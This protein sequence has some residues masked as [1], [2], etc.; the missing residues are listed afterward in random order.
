MISKNSP[1]KTNLF[2]DLIAFL[3][4][5]IPVTIAS[6]IHLNLVRLFNLS[7]IQVFLAL[8][9]L[10]ISFAICL[11]III[12]LF[13]RLVPKQIPGAYPFP[14]HLESK[15]W[16]FMLSLKKLV[17]FP[18]IKTFYFS[19][20]STKWLFLRAFRCRNYIDL[21]TGSNLS[22]SDPGLLEI[23]R[24]CMIAQNTHISCHYIDK[25]QLHLFPIKIGNNV[26]VNAYAIVSPGTVIGDNTVI[27]FNNSIY[28]HVEIGENVRLGA[29]V[30]IEGGAKIEDN[31]S[32]GAR[33]IIKSQ[34]IIKKNTKI[35]S[36]QIIS[37]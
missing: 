32:I 30:I 4:M 37:T 3:I 16:M 10:I 11:I 28:P 34:S 6:T 24:G 9:L 1:I 21:N 15:K 36:D 27:G 20:Y 14:K 26:S 2:L 31:C 22:L 18:T 35:E 29:Q 8:P 25:G 12:G 5:F 7:S 19:F 13:V 33:A 17:H 23:G